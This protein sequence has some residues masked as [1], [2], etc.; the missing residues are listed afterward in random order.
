MAEYRRFV[1]YIYA[2]DRG[3]KNKNVGFAKMEVR[4]GE[5]RIHVNIKGA[6]AASGKELEA[7]LFH[8][9]EEMLLGTWMGS[10]AIK[11]G[12]GEFKAVTSADNIGGSG[13]PLEEMNGVL[14]RHKGEEARIYASGW[15]D[16]AVTPENFIPVNQEERQEEKEYDVEAELAL[17]TERERLAA[18]ELMP[19][20]EAV[21][22]ELARLSADK[23]MEAMPEL[24]Q[25]VEMPEIQPAIRP[26]EQPAIQPVEEPQ[27]TIPEEQPVIQPMKEPQNMPEEQPA[28]HP[29]SEPQR[30]VPEEQPVV[31]PM[32]EPER[33][34]PEEQPVIQ[35]V[36]EP[37]RVIP[38]EPS[39]N[40]SM[41]KMQ[42]NVQRKQ[43]IPQMQKNMQ[44]KQS[45]PAKA[46]PQSFSQTDTVQTYT[47]QRT[48][49]GLWD[50]LENIFPK[51]VAFE[52]EPDISC[53]KIDLKDLE[54]LP[55]ENWGLANNS[56]LLHGYY[57]FRYLILAKLGEHQYMIGIPGMYHNNER[58]M[59][60]MFGFDHFK[61]VKDYKPL[62][63][64]FGYW[65]QWL[66]M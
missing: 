51:V 16:N 5:C 6:F 65:Y 21:E 55:R 27:R 4:N 49:H 35:P 2:Y 64:H 48:Y 46:E 10:F 61:P 43:P 30:V 59:A 52:D 63:G 29:M 45:I 19:V 28:V 54:Y 36:S 14:L 3:I 42:R 7:Y 15:D 33:D 62:T 13:L 9:E 25:P 34:I 17:T 47:E 60:A 57:N 53:L 20:M 24:E 50:R 40:Q 39:A 41:P 18:A 26:E 58:F 66:R 31:H 37:Q 1:S 11:N 23:D 22:E 8:R 56:F 32:P 12:N 38:E 44:K